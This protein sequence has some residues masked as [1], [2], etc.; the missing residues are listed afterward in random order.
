MTRFAEIQYIDGYLPIKDHGLIGDGTTAALVGCDG[1]VSWLCVPRFDSSPLFCSILDAGK[2]GRFSVE[3]TDAIESR[4]EYVRNTA[5][6]V[7]ELR[8]K[9]GMVR[10]TD[11]LTLKAGTDLSEAGD[12]SRRELL[13]H[14]EV[15]DGNVALRVALH[16]YG[17]PRQELQLVSS[18]P[19]TEHGSNICLKAGDSFHLSLRWGSD[20]RRYDDV[21]P[22]QAL[23][24]TQHSW[25]AWTR[26]FQYEGPQKPSVLRSAITLKLLDYRPNGAM[27]AAP[28]SSLPEVIG[29]VRNWDYRYSWVRDAAFSVY[30]LHRIGYS[31]EAGRLLHWLLESIERDNRAHVMYGLDGTPPP[32]ETE[33]RSLEGY[34]GSKPVRWGNAAARQIQHDV[35]GEILDCAYQWAGHHGSLEPPL[36]DK[37]ARLVEAAANSWRSPDHGV[38]EVRTMPRPFTYSAALCHVA[39]D[40]GIRLAER[41]ALPADLS[42]WR[43]A[44]DVI[45]HKILDDAW[46][47][48]RRSFTAHFGGR[49]GID[50]SLLSLP[51]RRVVEA[52]HPRM[53]AT[54]EAIQ[55]HLGAGNG[56]LYRYRVHESPD[57]L[58]GHENAFLLCSFWLVDNLTLQGRIREASDLYD[59]LCTKANGLGLLPEE[60][61][62]STGEFLG[63]FPQAF[64]HIGVICSGVNL[65][66]HI[67]QENGSGELA[68]LV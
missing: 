19:L 32:S 17:G 11:A 22:E 64:S 14:V 57:G 23:R 3:M 5:I 16:P 8:A 39:L 56:L 33:D 46:N 9:T 34:R 21:T 55:S 60:I 30:A 15:L 42:R 24:Q 18:M 6:L 49:G 68:S 62:P 43:Q 67:E 25:E 35:Y 52:N 65:H 29:G 7:T 2:G 28:T 31:A 51:L 10:L 41:L 66:R 47:A 38:W 53:V 13:R 12:S 58:P 61:D 37:L 50:A 59:Q 26:H 27:V 45:Q 40:R 44:R 20:P 54:T 36:W 63:N 48:D 4:Q 1:C